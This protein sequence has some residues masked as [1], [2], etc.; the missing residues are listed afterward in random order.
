MLALSYMANQLWTDLSQEKKAVIRVLQL[1]LLT[2]QGSNE[3]QSMLAAV[4]NIVAKPLEHAL[5][6]SQ[7]QNPKSQEIEPL[8][9][10]IKDNIRY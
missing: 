5:R 1:I 8:L 6:L 4:L 10:A 7:R 9:R 2:K 3:A